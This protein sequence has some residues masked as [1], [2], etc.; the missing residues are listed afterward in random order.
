VAADH[1]RESLYSCSFGVL[2][3]SGRK[4]DSS[5]A[6]SM[7]FNFFHGVFAEQRLDNMSA[8]ADFPDG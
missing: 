4:L 7:I 6:S 5:A 1:R 2:K 8:G 3:E